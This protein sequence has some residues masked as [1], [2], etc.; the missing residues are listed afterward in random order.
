MEM[1][2]D[3]KKRF[4][5]R[6]QGKEFILYG[7]LLELAK[8]K[9]IKRLEAEVVQI[10]SEANGNYAVCAALLEGADGSIYR[11]VGD[12]S[13]SNVNPTIAPHILRMAATRAKARALRDF[14]G[15]DMVALEELG[16]DVA[17]A[18]DGRSCPVA[19]PGK[20]AGTSSLDRHKA[21]AARAGEK[22]NQEDRRYLCA[23]CGAQ[24]TRSVCDFSMRKFGK[25]LCMA[26]QR[27]A[28]SE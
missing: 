18:D 4:V 2:E 23:E 26:C 19:T 1:S 14:T 11:E 8:E 16:G 27:K 28:A 7:G 13:P 24:I 5:K 10:P 9:G 17:G 6:L 3:F 15:V 21:R 12:A 22:D 20:V 25:P